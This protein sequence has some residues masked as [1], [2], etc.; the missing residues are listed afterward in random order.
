MEEMETLP[1]ELRKLGLTDKEARVYLAALA[2][3]YTSVQKIARQAQISR[4]TAYEVIKNLEKKGLMSESKE[5]GKKYFVAESPDRL[6]GLLHIQKREIEE[7]EREF[8]RIIADV[9]NKYALAGKNAIKT[10]QGENGIK[11]LLEDFLTTKAKEIY[12]LVADEKIWPT[13]Q[14][15]N[16]YQSIKN[17]LG[18]IEIKELAL[19]KK[20]SPFQGTVIMADKIIILLPGKKGLLIEN[21]TVVELIK[22]LAEKK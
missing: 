22:S 3:G 13:Q 6:L 7:K 9:K 10:Y 19:A 5:A 11:L 1:L 4:P 12:V 17:R 2:L 16:A 21:E 20:K 18:K 14:R 8:L 15:K